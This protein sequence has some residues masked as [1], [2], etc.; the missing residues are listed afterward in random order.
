[1]FKSVIAST[2]LV[3]ESANA[4][5]EKIRG[6]SFQGDVTFLSTLRALVAPRM[7]EEDTV[8]LSF[9]SSDFS[10]STVRNHDAQTV[11]SAICRYPNAVEGKSGIIQIH[12]FKSSYPNDNT[13]CFE[14]VESSFEKHYSGW[15]RLGKVTD[16]F[17]KTFAVLCFINPEKK[18][19]YLF[20]DGMDVKKMHYLQCSIFAFLPWY[21]DPEAGVSGIEM[22]LIESLREKTSQAYEACI[23]E[24]ASQYDFRTQQIRKL[25]SG[26]ELRY[27]RQKLESVRRDVLSYIRSI[28]DFNNRIGDLLRRKA[29][30]DICILGLEAKIAQGDSQDSEIMEY[31]LCNSNLVLEGVTNTYMEFTCMDYIT[32]F[33]EDMAKQMIDNHRS[34]IYRPN[35]RTCNNYIKEDDMKKL[36]NAIFIDQTLKVKVC[37]AYRFE[38]Q[39]NVIGM[40][41]YDYGYECHECFPNP[42]IDRYSCI[43]NYQRVINQLLQNH[44]Y[45]GA[46]EQC[47]ASCKSVNFADST[48][49]IEFMNRFYGITGDYSSIHCIEL[50]DG[51]TVTPR[52]A[53]KWLNTQEQESN[54]VVQTQEGA[55]SNE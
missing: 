4:F 31:F 55:E 20:T 54:E 38:L 17:R 23:A 47:I 49:M 15:H 32:Y 12:S 8:E 30:A 10:A 40:S 50:P 7:S 45:I 39:G 33:D 3:S 14:L 24:I 1:M 27:E 42:H 35:G 28:E 44:D 46:I 29:E 34:Y 19:A 26:F 48:V 11:L 51:K 41:G 6:D 53:V 22:K 16:F 52:Q 13:A 21:F 2:P 18:S 43:G 37:A 36:M 25:L 5:F 9:T